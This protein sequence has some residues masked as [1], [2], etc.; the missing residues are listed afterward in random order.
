MKYKTNTGYGRTLLCLAML[1]GVIYYSG[2]DMP[3]DYIEQ[4]Y[5]E[6]REYEEYREDVLL[7]DAQYKMEIDSLNINQ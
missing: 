5:K 4:K 2:R 3:E 6:A 7:Y 1:A